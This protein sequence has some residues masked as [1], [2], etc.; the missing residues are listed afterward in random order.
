MTYCLYLAHIWEGEKEATDTKL[1]DNSFQTL[2]FRSVSY[3][4]ILSSWLQ[5]KDDLG[6]FV[7][8]L[9]IS[10]F[11]RVQPGREL[12]GQHRAE[13]SPLWPF[14][15]IQGGINPSVLT[16]LLMYIWQW[17]GPDSGKGRKS[18]SVCMPWLKWSFLI[19]SLP[20]LD[21]PWTW[22]SVGKEGL[23][24]VAFFQD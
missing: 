15:N 1:R 3:Q 5:G 19:M 21:L 22:I 8:F 2:F 12:R 11:F 4:F 23:S 13:R 9:G 10:L 24:T 14:K 20:W 17:V 6:N 18:C 7:V 16:E